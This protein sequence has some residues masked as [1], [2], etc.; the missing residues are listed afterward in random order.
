[1]T[2]VD[3]NAQGTPGKVFKIPL[4]GGGELEVQADIIGKLGDTSYDEILFLGLKAALSKGL[5][6]AVGV[7]KGLSADQLEVA[8][9]KG[10]EKAKAN[11]EALISG[12]AKTSKKK[13]VKTDRALQ[14]EALRIA[15]EMVRNGLIAA[16]EKVSYRPLSEIT[17]AAKALIEANPTILEMAQANMDAAANATKAVS[18][19]LA[20]IVKTVKPSD[21]LIKAA[22]EKK[23][24]A[25][26]DKPLSA[27]QAG[28][29]KKHIP[30]KPGTVQATA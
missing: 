10:V 5:D 7:V 24:K 15:R 12:T 18:E 8:K 30:A 9:A 21:K 16:G 11:L 4:K 2:N 23:A 14:S 17:L 19:K 20:E 13:A 27:K 25:A 28:K 1:M 26:A 22:A 29:T 6:K 3:T